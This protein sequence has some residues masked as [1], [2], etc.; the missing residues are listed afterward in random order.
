VHNTQHYAI[1]YWWESFLSPLLDLRC[2][3][4]IEAVSAQHAL[5]RFAEVY[6]S[7]LE[8]CGIKE[9]ALMERK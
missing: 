7:H 1:E 8:V 4:I 9:L 6:G 5:A 2:S 3:V